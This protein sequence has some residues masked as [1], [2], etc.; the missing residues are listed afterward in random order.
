MSLVH[1][2]SIFLGFLMFEV[3]ERKSKLLYGGNDDSVFS[4][5]CIRQFLGTLA[6]I[7][8]CSCCYLKIDHVL[9]HISIEHYTV[10]YHDD[11]VKDS[12]TIWIRHVGKLI[13][14]PSHSLGF[15]TSCGMLN[16][17][18]VSRSFLTNQTTKFSHG[19]ELMKTREYNH[20]T[21]F[22]F[23]SFFVLVILIITLDKIFQDV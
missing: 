8:N 4:V 17:I 1:D 19:T 10:C 18:I 23:L 9:S 13:C 12:R 11:A 15:S 2:D 14:E 16:Q 6:N 5:K 21:L 7:L 22:L 20:C 3:I